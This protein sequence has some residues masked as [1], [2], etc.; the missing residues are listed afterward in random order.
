MKYLIQTWS[1]AKSSDIKLLEVHDIGK[2]LD[3]NVQPEKQVIKSIADI[4]MKEVSQIKSRLSQGRAGWRCKIK[5]L[6]S[7]VQAMEK[8]PKVLAPDTPMLQVKVVPKPNFTIPEMKHTG[9]TSSRKTIQDVSRE[10]HIYP[11]PV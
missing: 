11:D 7:I 1:W 8:Q 3:P 2:G 6:T 4:E 9:D 5:T 10:I